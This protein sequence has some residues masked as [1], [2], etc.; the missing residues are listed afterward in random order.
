VTT[1]LSFRK[2]PL[3]LS[4]FRTV[5]VVV[6][7]HFNFVSQSLTISAVDSGFIVPNNICK[8]RFDTPNFI[9]LIVDPPFLYK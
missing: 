7:F 9:S 3:S 1:P 6:R 5:Y 4:L 2:S 8:A